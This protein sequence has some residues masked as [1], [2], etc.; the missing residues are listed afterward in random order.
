MHQLYS[1]IAEKTRRSAIA[2][3]CPCLYIFEM[4]NPFSYCAVCGYRSSPSSR[5]IPLIHCDLLFTSRV[6]KHTY[7]QFS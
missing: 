1:F 2:Y 5:N 3:S 4:D 6:A 7:I